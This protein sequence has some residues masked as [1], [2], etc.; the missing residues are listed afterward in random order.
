MFTWLL[1]PRVKGWAAKCSAIP[2]SCHSVIGRESVSHDPFLRGGDRTATEC[3]AQKIT[4]ESLSAKLN[5][6]Q[7]MLRAEDGRSSRKERR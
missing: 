4:S 5:L 6:T 1:T 3:K 7:Q 2:N